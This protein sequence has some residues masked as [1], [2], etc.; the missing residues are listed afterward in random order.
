MTTETKELSAQ[1][2]AVVIQIAQGKIYRDIAEDLGLAA[3]TV[4][5]YAARARSKLGLNN[6]VK[7]AMWARDQGLLETT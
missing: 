7:L 3:E 1:E 6:K 5:K 4:R 2:R